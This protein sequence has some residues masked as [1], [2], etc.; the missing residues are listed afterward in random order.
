MTLALLLV[1]VTVAVY[2]L[3]QLF[4]VHH[5]QLHVVQNR[6]GVL[7]TV[8]LPALLYSVAVYWSRKQQRNN[9]VAWLNMLSITFSSIA[10]IAA[11]YGMIEYHFSIF[12]VLAI[13]SYY[14]NIKMLS[15]MSGIFVVQHLLGYLYLTEYVFGVPR[16]EYSFTMLL[17]HA[18]F[19]LGTTGAL[20]WQIS[21]KRSL[22]QQLQTTQSEQMM[23]AQLLDQMKQSSHQLGDVSHKLGH[24]YSYA[25]GELNN[26]AV[27]M[28]GM[29][30]DARQNSVLTNNTAMVVQGISDSLQQISHANHEVVKGAQQMSHKALLGEQLMS[31][32]LEQMQ[33]LQQQCNH[34]MEVIGEL[35]RHAASVQQM[36]DFIRDIAK[37]TRMLA[38]NASI[39]AARAGGQGKGFAVVALE[40]GKLAQQSNNA[41]IQIMEL[42][43]DVEQKAE[44]AVIVMRELSGKVAEG[45]TYNQD[46]MNLL[47]DISSLIKDSTNQFQI[48]SHSTSTIAENTVQGNAEITELN[49]NAHNILKKAEQ[50]AHATF[51]QLELNAEL[52]PLITALNSI[53]EDLKNSENN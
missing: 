49:R 45:V 7:I 52:A 16:G 6:L 50:T 37:Q 39:E 48:V 31:R 36:S 12:M 51:R 17:Y 38:L 33:Q 9:M 20:I 32:T 47:Q 22:R 35:H 14:E 23:L 24:M 28:Q 25:Q 26:M 34:Y 40:V 13:V 3:H 42:A 1:L 41:T 4:V 5:T 43:A 21:H 2:G 30:D 46:M 53:A 44:H 18:L 15:V 10:M 19:L 29:S 8:I 11:G 27:A